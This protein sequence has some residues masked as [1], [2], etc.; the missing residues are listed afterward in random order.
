MIS[1]LVHEPVEQQGNTNTLTSFPVFY[2]AKTTF[3]FSYSPMCFYFSDL[4]ADP[5]SCACS[6]HI[7]VKFV[8][9]RLLDI[10]K[11]Y[12]R[13]LRDVT[14]IFLCLMSSS[15]CDVYL[16]RNLGIF[17]HIHFF[18]KTNLKNGF[19]LNFYRIICLLIC[20]KYLQ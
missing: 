13:R 8:P 7:F 15:P 1:L 2:Y 12:K 5:L 19:A 14:K 6:C 9:R 11:A 18:M 16:F 4:L 10:H 20:L 3:R 17:I